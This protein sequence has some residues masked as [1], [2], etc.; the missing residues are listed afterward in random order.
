MDV[1]EIFGDRILVGP[2]GMVGMVDALVV[3]MLVRCW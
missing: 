3:L 2:I 1:E